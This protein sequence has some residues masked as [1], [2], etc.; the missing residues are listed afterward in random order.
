MVLTLEH[1]ENIHGG[2]ERCGQEVKTWLSGLSLPLII[3]IVK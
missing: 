1:I 2:K 3:V